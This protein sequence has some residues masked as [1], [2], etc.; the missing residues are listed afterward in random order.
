MPSET[1]DGTRLSREQDNRRTN[2]HKMKP[3]GQKSRDVSNLPSAQPRDEHRR[4]GLGLNILATTFPETAYQC[5][6]AGPFVTP[7][8]AG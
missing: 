4:V 3:S 8:L 6:D 1:K 7:L 5:F 2:S